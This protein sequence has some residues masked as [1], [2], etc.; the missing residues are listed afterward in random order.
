MG[1]RI[2]I[3]H[4][5]K[6]YVGTSNNNNNKKKKKISKEKDNIFLFIKF[7]IKILYV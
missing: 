2:A 6:L 4:T 5:E 7:L 3:K 1:S